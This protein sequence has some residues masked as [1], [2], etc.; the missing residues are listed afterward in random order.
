[1]VELAHKVVIKRAYE[2]PKRDD[3]VRV[4]VDRL[5]PRGLRKDDAH[6]D[7]WRKDVSSSTALREFYGHRPERFAEFATRCR[8]ELRHKDAAAAAA[9]LINLAGRR[10]V[11][12]DRVRDAL[13]AA[14]AAKPAG[15]GGT[16]VT[17]TSPVRASGGDD[18][19]C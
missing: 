16:R 9:A 3:G 7:A 19:A 11:T 6:F 13:M 8:A 12:R 17:A 18:V 1:M 10:P 15:L 2:P 14:I 5:W 4:L